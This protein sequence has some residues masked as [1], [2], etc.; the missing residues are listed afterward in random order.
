MEAHRDDVLDGVILYGEGWSD[1]WVQGSLRLHLPFLRE[2]P[3]EK[4][5]MSQ[6]RDWLVVFWRRKDRRK[7]QPGTIYAQVAKPCGEAYFN[8]VTK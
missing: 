5:L 2:N 3:K 1:P 8:A 7:D 6:C 4:F